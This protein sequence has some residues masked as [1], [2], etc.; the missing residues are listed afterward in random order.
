MEIVVLL[1]GDGVERMGKINSD[2]TMGLVGGLAHNFLL[3]V[4]K[5]RVTLWA[6]YELFFLFAKVQ[7]LR[8][9][10]CR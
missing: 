10:G 7:W 3:L 4:A 6:I 1:D 8:G 9:G 2:E 5:G